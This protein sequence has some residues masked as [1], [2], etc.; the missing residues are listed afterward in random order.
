MSSRPVVIVGASAAGLGCARGLRHHGYADRLIVV[1][2]EAHDP[3]DRPPLS[4]QI[5]SGEWPPERVTLG[6]PA[7]FSDLGVE[8][9]LSTQAAALDLGRRAV[10]LDTAEMIPFAKLV[11]ATG[12]SPRIPAGASG[13]RGVHILRTLD[14]ALALREAFSRTEQVTVIGGGLLGAEVAATARKLGLTVDMVY[15]E[16]Y[17]NE[18]P[19]GLALA[20]V[21]HD[22]HV[23]NGVRLHPR[24]FVERVDGH[25]GAVTAVRFAGGESMPTRLVVACV[26]STPNTG[27]LADSGLSLIE[28]VDCDSACS[29]GDGIFAAG[30]VA[31]W[32][33]RA[34][35]RRVRAEHQANALEQGNAV[36]ENLAL[37][38]ARAYEPVPYFWTDQYGQRMQ[39]HGW[40]PTDAFLH[41]TDGSITADRFAAVAHRDGL[42][43]GTI[44]FNAA[45]KLGRLR[46]LIGRPFNPSTLATS[47]S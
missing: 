27:W 9:K 21:M 42:V 20:P 11:I 26:G 44:G 23:R 17:V 12:V 3:Y 5:L 10:L 32:I 39:V 41:F 24:T 7:S 46:G 45:R 38:S 40:W 15:A 1:G 34:S 33:D 8:L 37:G 2:A 31:S 16:R 22:L 6:T 25:G 36:A 47:T 18:V 28:G 14:D 43:V 35:G 30:D 29:V 19:L 4:K 13:L